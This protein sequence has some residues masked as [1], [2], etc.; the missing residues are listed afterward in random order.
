MDMS[1]KGENINFIG[2][3]EALGKNH[4]SDLKRLDYA[5]IIEGDTQA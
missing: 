2:K 3:V 1:M 5:D 4:K